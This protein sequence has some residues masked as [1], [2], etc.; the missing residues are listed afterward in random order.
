MYT[1][2]IDL[3]GTNIVAGVV[4]DKYEIVATA[5]VKTA[6]PRPAEAICDDMAK[7]VF[8]AVEKAGI[9]MEDIQWVG[10]GSPGS[11]NMETGEVEFANNLNFHHTP[12]AK[13]MEER[14]NKKIYIEND[15]NAA[16]YGEFYAGAARGTKNAVAITL[17]TGVGGGI[18]INEKIYSG[19]NSAGAELGHICIVKDGRPC[20]CGRNGCWESYASATALIYQTKCAMVDH[21]ESVMWELTD[22]DIRKASGRTAFDAMRKGDAAGKAVVDQYLEY[23]ACGLTDVINIFQPEVLCIGGG[24]SK[25][26]ET[27]LAPIRAYVEKERYSKYA[28]KQTKICAAELGNDAGIIGAALLGNLMD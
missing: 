24:I 14:V 19:S 7:V 8:E 17:G 11:C 15:A 27:L 13:L 22:N 12:I 10:I 21:P 20:S 6:M 4:N 16:A 1:V 18:I 5:K 9:T 23:V 3:G 2:G 26:G 28:A 25:E